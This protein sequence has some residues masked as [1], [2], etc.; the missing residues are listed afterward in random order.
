MSRGGYGGYGGGGLR[1]GGMRGGQNKR[2][3][4]FEEENEGETEQSI[5]AEILLSVCVMVFLCSRL[6]CEFTSQTRG[7]ATSQRRRAAGRGGGKI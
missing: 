4:A 3:Q 5:Y 7:F 6:S 1:G 2:R